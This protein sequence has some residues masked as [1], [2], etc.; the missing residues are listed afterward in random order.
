MKVKRAKTLPYNVFLGETKLK[1]RIQVLQDSRK[2]GLTRLSSI[3]V[4]M[5]LKR[6]RE[7][8][9]RS[10]TVLDE[11]LGQIKVKIDFAV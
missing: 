3:A 2:A 6:R 11:V 5:R 10:K 7:E 8:R 4:Y 9:Q 1:K